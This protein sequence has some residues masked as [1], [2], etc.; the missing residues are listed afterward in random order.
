MKILGGSMKATKMKG[1]GKQNRV[2]TG[3]QETCRKG[4]IVKVERFEIL[5]NKKDNIVSI[6]EDLDEHKIQINPVKRY[7]KRFGVMSN[8]GKRA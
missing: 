4:Y 6:L 5:F 8:T 3:K 7:I 2:K 1:K